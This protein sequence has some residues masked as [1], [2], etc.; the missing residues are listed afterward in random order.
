MRSSPFTCSGKRRRTSSLPVVSSAQQRDARARDASEVRILAER[1][2]GE[3]LK[4]TPKHPGGNPNLSQ[5]STGSPATLP[6]LGVTRDESS[7]WQKLA[8]VPT[9][10]QT[11]DRGAPANTRDVPQACLDTFPDTVLVAERAS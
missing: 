9:V 5:S 8:A 4:E 10:R 7:R 3:L 11:C 2:A 6:E 1:K